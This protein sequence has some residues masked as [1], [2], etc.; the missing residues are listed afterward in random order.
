MLYD[1]KIWN[2][3]RIPEGWKQGLIVKLPKGLQKLKRDN[4]AVCSGKIMGRM[5]IDRIR[6]GVE[7][8]LRKEEAGCRKGRGTTDQVFIL[9]NIIEQANEWQAT[10]YL[11]FIDFEK[12][13]D[14]IHRQRLW[15]IIHL[16]P[17]WPPFN[18]SFV[19]IQT[20]P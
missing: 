5:I 11:N 12:A 8:R 17:K 9:R 14:S 16:I 19:F 6:K 13:L 4:V 15:E 2:H 18:Y 7:R 10:L 20:S 3:E 1:D